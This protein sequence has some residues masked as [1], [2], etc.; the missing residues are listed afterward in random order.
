[1]LALL[2]LT[3]AMAAQD[4]TLKV[5]DGTQIHALA[6]PVAGSEKGVVLVHMQGRHAGDWSYFGEKL[7]RSKMQ[8]VMPDL[9][10]HGKNVP[11][12]Q[13][14]PLAEADYLA[15]EGDVRAAVAWLR[16]QGVKQVSCV[17]AALGANLCAKVAADDPQVV[18]LALLSPG[19]NYKGVRIADAVSRY[20]DRPLLMVASQDDSYAYTTVIKLEERAKDAEVKLFE[21]AGNGTK[22]LSREP[23]LEGMLQSWLIG[24]YQLAS[25]GVVRPRPAATNDAR[26][27]QATGE[28][29]N[30]HQ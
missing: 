21:K 28:K 27:V 13:T 9:R 19:L 10:G 26:D 20:G 25:G 18:N 11:E 16:A 22:M 24:S 12:G 14:A 29:L 30:S 2:T 5:D 17:G 23:E 3:A 15:M 4:L 6:E 1:M 7:A 8:V